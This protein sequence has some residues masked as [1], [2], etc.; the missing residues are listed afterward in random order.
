MSMYMTE[1]TGAYADLYVVVFYVCMCTAC[2]AMTNGAMM[3][4]K[5]TI[6]YTC[7]HAL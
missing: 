1:V 3:H 5:K 2:M 7:I 4:V 6:F